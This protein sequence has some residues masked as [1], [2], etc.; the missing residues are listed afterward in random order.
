MEHPLLEKFDEMIVAK[1]YDNRSEAI[2]D[3]VKRSLV[4]EGSL[5]EQSE[6]AGT[7]TLIYPYRLKMRPVDAGHHPSLVILA[8]LQVHLDHNTCLK[9]LVVKGN[10]REVQSF[11]DRLLGTKGVLGQFNI[12]TT[13][14]IYAE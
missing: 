6:V 9:V 7:I 4:Q 5:A 11:A 12:S 13:E 14:D 1:G 8:N 10:G 3:L 2:R